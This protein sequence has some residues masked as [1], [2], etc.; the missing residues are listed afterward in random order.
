MFKDSTEEKKTMQQEDSDEED[1]IQHTARSSSVQAQR[2]PIF[3]GMDHSALK[4][5][6]RKRQVSESPGEQSSAQLFK[7]PK[8]QLQLG[9]AGSRVLPS[10][11]EK[12][13]RSE[14]KSP[15]WLKELKSKKRQSHH[16]NQ[17]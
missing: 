14:E 6:L 8:P 5:Q 11:V 9:A 13:D 4:A 2:L 3:P 15:Q 7:S 16:E 1:K 12:E 10:N 17:V